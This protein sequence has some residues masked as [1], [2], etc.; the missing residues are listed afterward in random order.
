V[1]NTVKQHDVCPYLVP[2]S[3]VILQSQS[4]YRVNITADDSQF[5]ITDCNI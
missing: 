4:A 2:A 1:T 5:T 3:F